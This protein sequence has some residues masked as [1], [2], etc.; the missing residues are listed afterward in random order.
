MKIEVAQHWYETK[1]F[2]DEI[3]LILESHVNPELRCNIWHV[4][5]KTRDLLVDSGMGF[6]SLRESIS[7]L[8][9]RPVAAVAS[10]THFD[11]IGAHDEFDQ[12]LCH[13]LEAEIMARPTNDATLWTMYHAEYQ[14]GPTLSALPH[15]GYD[16]DKYAIQPAPPTQL[17]DEGDEIDLGNRLFRVFHMPG[18]SPGSLCLYEEQ[19]RTLFTGDVLYDGELLDMLHH[20]DIGLYRETMARLREFPADVFHCG[21]NASFGKTRAVEL[22]DQYL[23]SRSDSGC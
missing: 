18:H 19:T 8:N 17:I 11:H 20:S 1:N 4:R 22:I 14:V 21:H 15:A 12:R 13:P 2:S 5:G 6:V 23:E 9:E 10:H 16:L 3:T 7:A